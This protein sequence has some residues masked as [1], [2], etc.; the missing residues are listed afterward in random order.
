VSAQGDRWTLTAPPATWRELQV[1]RARLGHALGREQ[2]DIGDRSL[3]VK[4]GKEQLIV[5]LT[6][7]DA[8]RRASP[9]TSKTRRRVPQQLISVDGVSP[10]SGR[11]P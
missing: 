3:W 10:C 4:A 6:S 5:P 7:E 1:P 8:L 9:R 11:C 2:S